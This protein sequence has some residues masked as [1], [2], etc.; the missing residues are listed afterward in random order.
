M[1]MSE[2]GSESEMGQFVEATY[3]TDK[4]TT[5][6]VKV[7]LKMKKANYQQRRRNQQTYKKGLG[8]SP[9]RVPEWK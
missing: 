1:D 2:I 3:L 5:S 6:N 8:M 9:K 7:A 4:K